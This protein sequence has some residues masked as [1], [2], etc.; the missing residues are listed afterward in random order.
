MF[1]RIT[2]PLIFGL[3]LLSAPAG[4]EDQASPIEVTIKDHRFSPSEIH[5]PAGKPA[6]LL[7]RNTD[8]TAEEVDSKALGV[9]KVVPAGAQT[10]IRLRP[11]KPG[12]YPFAGEYHSETAQGAVIAE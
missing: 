6:L 1:I 8:A 3:C 7:F 5:L 9:E 4:A 11:L 12:R 10:R 2:L